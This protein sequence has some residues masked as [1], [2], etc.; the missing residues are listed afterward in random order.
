M[1]DT[2]DEH[3]DGVGNQDDIPWEEASKEAC[4]E[5]KQENNVEEVE[6]DFHC[7]CLHALL[8]SRRRCASLQDFVSPL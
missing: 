5:P 1:N 2:D 4:L 6:E 7:C 3:N 8:S